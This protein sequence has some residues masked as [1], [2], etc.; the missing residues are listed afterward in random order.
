MRTGAPGVRLAV[1]TFRRTADIG[2]NRLTHGRDG[3]RP[4]PRM[5]A[6]APGAPAEAGA[7]RPTIPLIRRKT[8]PAWPSPSAAATAK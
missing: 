5:D 3:L 8:A 6:P 4:L 1:P 7:Y 2:R